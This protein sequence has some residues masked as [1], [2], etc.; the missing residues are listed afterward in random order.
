MMEKAG[1]QY[2]RSHASQQATRHDDDDD[3]LSDHHGPPPADTNGTH[4]HSELADLSRQ[5]P[6]TTTTA[7][8]RITQ[9]HGRKS[10]RTTK[11]TPRSSWLLRTSLVRFTAHSKAHDGRRTV[12]PPTKPGG[13][14]RA[15]DRKGGGESS[16]KLAS[17]RPS[18]GERTCE[19][20]SE[21]NKEITRKKRTA[22]REEA[23]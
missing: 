8:Q 10:P 4:R 14:E 7:A 1:A 2:T 16:A 17:A 23:A 5:R 18:A 11:T 22:Q 21:R 9:G 12:P 13:I 20:A 3:P 6:T 19:R 15:R